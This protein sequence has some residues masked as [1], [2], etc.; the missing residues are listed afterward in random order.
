MP[1]E[2]SIL[3]PVY[4]IVDLTSNYLLREG[5]EGRDGHDGREIHDGRDNLFVLLA[6]G[7]VSLACTICHVE[8]K[9]NVHP[10]NR[11]GRPTVTNP[12]PGH[13]GCQSQ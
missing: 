10:H 2:Y 7:S 4:A 1:K 8:V 11:S 13:A 5:Q 9:N 3:R 6:A 12:W